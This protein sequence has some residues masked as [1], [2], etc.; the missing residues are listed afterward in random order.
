MSSDT[1]TSISNTLDSFAAL[2]LRLGAVVAG[3]ALAYLLYVIFG[4]KLAAMKAM[5]AA[6]KATLL[7]SVGW[8]R[9]MLTWGG[10]LLVLSMCIRF[11]YEETI[12]VILTS[13]GAGLY[14]LSP[15]GLASLTMA[16]YTKDPLYQGIVGDIALVGL[17]CLVPG[18]LLLV[19][20][21]IWRITKRVGAK[22]VLQTEEEK[23]RA[24]RL[25]RHRKPYEKCW[26]MSVCNERTR[27]F[28]PAWEKRKP[29]WR[30]KSGC[31]CDE[32]IMKQAMLARDRE[33]GINQPTAAV[34]SRPKVVMTPQQKK[35]RCRSCTVYMEHQRQKFKLASPAAL[36]LVAVIY[37]VLYRQMY[38]VL[39]GFFNHMDRFMSFL[40][41]HKGPAE[42]FSS[43]GNSVTTLGM[44]CLAVVLLSFTFRL[45][46]WLI[47]DRQV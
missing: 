37:A 2:G 9:M 12:G 30:I 36:V 26:D 40:T 34:D 32:N 27:R 45:V 43:K 3:L 42:S 22:H 39:Y 41:Y 13:V 16:S 24:Q 21:V 47:F 25:N 7:Q 5:N 19:R 18:C 10:G 38:S 46:E 35:V 8:A 28:C 31:L 20:D 14:F 6:D 33:A 11:F 4:P 15:S 23:A 17:F 1:R 29:C 44:I